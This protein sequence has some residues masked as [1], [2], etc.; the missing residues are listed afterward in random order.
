MGPSQAVLDPLRVEQPRGKELSWQ[1][2]ERRLELAAS[3]VYRYRGPFPN[4]G[5][6]AA[7]GGASRQP[8]AWPASA[9][10]NHRFRE[11]A[12]MEW[13]LLGNAMR[14]LQTNRECL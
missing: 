6:G 1:E 14:L 10:R 11:I 12:L 4:P 9:I 2:V 8:V 3:T 7:S 13:S 5:A